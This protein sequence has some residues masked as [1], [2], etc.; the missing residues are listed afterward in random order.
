MN[1]PK[2]YFVPPNIAAL[3][4]YERLIPYLENT[5]D[6]GFLLVRHEGVLLSEVKAMKEES[7]QETILSQPEVLPSAN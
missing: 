6:P 1:K 4:Y 2:I 7:L 3:K 5:Y